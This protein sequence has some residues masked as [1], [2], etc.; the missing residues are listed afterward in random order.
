MNK[1]IH[2]HIIQ[3]VPVDYYQ[4]GVKNNIFQKI[5]HTNKLKNVIDYI[6][7]SSQKILDVGCAGGWFISQVSNKF[8]KARCFGIDIYEEAITYARK[9]YPYIEFKIADAHKLRYKRDIRCG[10][11]Y[12]SFGTC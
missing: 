3:Q 6:P 10:D 9:R 7:N 8:S 1:K 12:R 11:L 4:V 2:N 5:W